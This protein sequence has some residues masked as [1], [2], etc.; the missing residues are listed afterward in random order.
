[1]PARCTTKPDGSVALP[2]V[3]FPDRKKKARV[4][5]W[6]AG[7]LIGVHVLIIAHI[8]QWLV[9]GKTVSPI[10]PS[11]SMQT[12]EQGLLNAGAIFFAIAILSTVLFGRYVCGWLCHVVALQDFCHWLMGKAGIRPKPFRARLLMLAPLALGLYMFVWPSF[13]RYALQPAFEA[14]NLAWPWWLRRTDPFPGIQAELVVDDFWATFPEWYIAIPFLLVCG[15]ATVYFLGA[16][17]FCFY[18]CPYGGIFALVEPASPTRVRVDHDKCHECGLCTAACTS[19]VRV[20]EEIK[21]FGMVVDAGCMKTMD[22]INACPN[23]ALSIGLGRP[24][25]GAPARKE[26]R[27]SLDAAKK[28]ATRRWDLSWPEE[29]AFAL[30][31][32]FLFIATRGMFDRVPMLMAGGLAA[33]GTGLTVLFWKTL[34][35][36][37]ARIHRLLL[38][39]KGKVRPAGI[40]FVALMLAG[41]TAAAWGGTGNITRWRAESLHA[42]VG[43]PVDAVLRP[44]FAPSE[45]ARTR[46][47]AALEWFA[48]ADSFANGGLGWELNPDDHVRLAYLHAVLGEFDAAVRELRVVVDEGNPTD[49]LVFQLLSL[50]AAAARVEADAAPDMAIRGQIIARANNEYLDILRDA[51]DKHPALH[52]VRL[53]LAQEL[54]NR[55]TYDAS[56]WDV[57]DPEI[58]ADPKFILN[59]GQLKA[60]A[61]DRDGMSATL[62]RVLALEPESPA[63]LF[64]ASQLARSIGR[65]TDADRLLAE[66]IEH[67][68]D[69]PT[70]LNAANLFL[71]MGKANDARR[72][73][74]KARDARGGPT[75]GVRFQIGRILLTLGDADEGLA[76]MRRAADDL[77]HDPWQELG[78]LN[79][80]AQIASD[81]GNQAL[82]DDTLDRLEALVQTHPGE[83]V[84]RH[85]LS[86]YLFNAGRDEDAMA[87]IAE[88][89]R[90]GESS[91]VLA[92]RAAQLH[93]ALGR[94]EQ[95]EQWQQRA[96]DRL[97]ARTESNQDPDRPAPQP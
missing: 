19:N 6:R 10:E 61:G 5:K 54:W 50:H 18:A 12:L 17:A 77:A 38:K 41:W 45:T 46:A 9:I 16:K 92:E 66:G 89:A 65:S 78:V 84:F 49:G 14:M 57:N 62:D 29:I 68:H 22:C 7:V 39:H 63:I 40:V 36:P 75:P 91:V 93:A 74:D 69:A 25:L 79:A 35:A 71:N 64:E 33:V 88:A 96:A 30:V 2:V 24:A 15:F 52:T 56:I 51:L 37:N 3:T 8:I 48:K 27:A 86:G 87:Q 67:A 85:D 81:T 82:L 28:K 80:L 31:F 95:A 47:R 32:L 11:E 97:R 4:G 59:S 73:I 94:P 53:R 21:H 58:A 43:I 34:A 60:L 20:H 42:G 23:D 13:K 76:L 44:E 1:M 72:M 55:G 70:F 26:A 90:I 83:P